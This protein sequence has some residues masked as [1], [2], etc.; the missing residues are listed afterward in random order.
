M[1]AAGAVLREEQDRL[2]ITP[3]NRALGALVTA[4][5]MFPKLRLS[6]LLINA[7]GDHLY[8]VEDETLAAALEKYVKDYGRG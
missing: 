4:S 2:G 3:R 7:A 5:T 6:Q 1:S 8:Y